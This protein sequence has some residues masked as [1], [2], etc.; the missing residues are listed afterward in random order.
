MAPSSPDQA[1]F[2][3][4]F[5][6]IVALLST[7]AMEG[8]V[9]ALL[10]GD[11][12]TIATDDVSAEK[13][14]GSQL[15]AIGDRFLPDSRGAGGTPLRQSV[16]LRPRP[17]ILDEPGFQEAHD[18]AEV[19]VA[20]VMN[21]F[22]EVWCRRLQGLG[23]DTPKQLPRNRV[24]EEGEE[25]ARQLLTMAI[26]AIDY[27]PPIHLDFGD[28]LSALLTADTEVRPDDDRYDLRRT[29]IRQCGEYGIRPV[30]RPGSDGRWAR[31]TRMPSSAGAPEPA[32]DT[33][34]GPLV[35]DLDGINFTDLQTDP[36]EMFRLIWNNRDLLRLNAEAYT[37]V[38]SVRPSVRVGPE[39]GQI[40]HEIVA[41][42][43]QYVSVR[44]ADLDTIDHM[45][46]PPGVAD[47]AVIALEGGSTLILDEYGRLKYEI[48]N[49]LP[50]PNH[51]AD[52]DEERRFKGLQN[53]IER[54]ALLGY[55][56]HRPSA[57]RRIA[58]L[59]AHRYADAAARASRTPEVW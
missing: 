41:E 16:M 58:D 6:D 52:P 39:D 53:R 34:V 2:H 15:F 55:Y 42:C 4:A 56:D 18:R 31:P 57:T 14:K 43:L 32:D 9:E 20:A 25:I 3:E 27:T 5:A 12:P 59:H 47:D 35:L 49:R 13:L 29:L 38:T 24:A 51:A 30:S 45:R 11:G 28:F 8:V 17:G 21:T 44:A 26:R 10:G 1:A 7:Y 33:D 36:A 22:V 46:P 37:H 40:V 48:S 50:D 54:L 19:L 23:S